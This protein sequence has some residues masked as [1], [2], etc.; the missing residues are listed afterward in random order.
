MR[1]DRSDQGFRHMVP[2][3]L[4]KRDFQFGPHRYAGRGLGQGWG[5]RICSICE[6]AN[7]DGI[8]PESHPDLMAH[9]KSRG[10]PIRLNSKGWLPIPPL[11]T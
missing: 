1:S 9:L 6:S 7:W 10:V 4:C 3:I 8:V 2:C 11:G 5:V